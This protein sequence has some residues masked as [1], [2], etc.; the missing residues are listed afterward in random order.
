MIEIRPLVL[1]EESSPP[2]ALF[3]FNKLLIRTNKISFLLVVIVN[4][5]KLNGKSTRAF[6]AKILPKEA[7]TAFPKTRCLAREA[8]LPYLK[9]LSADIDWEEIDIINLLKKQ[10]DKFKPVNESTSKKLSYIHISMSYSE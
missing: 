6:H 5:K 10:L 4:F 2:T 7:E 9:M 8:K 3:F 1:K